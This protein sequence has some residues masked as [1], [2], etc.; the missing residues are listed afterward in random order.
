MSITSRFFMFD[1]SYPVRL[2]L[3]LREA[4]RFLNNEG[5]TYISGLNYLCHVLQEMIQNVPFS[6]AWK[7][8]EPRPYMPPGAE[9][10]YRRPAWDAIACEIEKLNALGYLIPATPESKAEWLSEQLRLCIALPKYE[11]LVQNFCTAMLTVPARVHLGPCTTLPEPPVVLTGSFKAEAEN[12]KK[13]VGDIADS[14]L[15][16]L[17]KEDEKK[18]A[19]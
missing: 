5:E 14:L 1:E 13:V 4:K 3:A 7:T 2:C 11:A 6:P 17:S 18:S 12:A 10:K 8:N 19:A 9:Y 16:V 15:I